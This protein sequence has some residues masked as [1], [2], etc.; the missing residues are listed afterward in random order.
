MNRKLEAI[1]NYDG[2]T[3]D[4][5][6]MVDLTYGEQIDALQTG[7]LDALYQ[8]V[9]GSNIEELASQHGVRWLD[10][11]GDDESRYDTWEELAPMVRPG[12]FTGA[13]MEEGE[14]AVNMQYSIPL[15]T[16]ADRSV[17]EV[18]TLVQGI[19]ENFEHFRDAT[20]DAENFGPQA[21]LLD[22]LVV[23]FHEGSVEYFRSIG[24]WTD[25]LQARNEALLEREG[26]L[27]D[28]WPG[29]WES[30]AD[31]EDIAVRWKSWKQENLPQLPE[32]DDVE[33]EG[34]AS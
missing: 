3:G 33:D 2:L 11:G 4:D 22:P 10:L 1:L 30:H 5:V 24:R 23:P 20:P 13:G 14:S 19:E 28:A 7:H 27:V 31:A 21:V 25:D 17:E 26:L 12:E 16:L 9:V 34:D 29:F 32:V 18:T 8:N 6:Q 15:T